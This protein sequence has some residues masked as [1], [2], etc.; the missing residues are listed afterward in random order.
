[1]TSAHGWN[2][3]SAAG[4]DGDQRGHRSPARAGDS[5]REAWADVVSTFGGVVLLIS[6]G[7]GALQ[8]MSAIV[9]DDLY[10]QGSDYLYAFDMQVWGTVHLVIAIL[11]AIVGVG[12]LAQR[13]WGY[14]GGLVAAGLSIIGNFAFLPHYPLWSITLIALGVLV[15]WALLVRL[16]ADR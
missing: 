13:A 4:L 11:S 16:G 8:G 1:M 10:S 15:I 9:N 14:V 3:G 6:A 12:V 2:G 7:M 5:A